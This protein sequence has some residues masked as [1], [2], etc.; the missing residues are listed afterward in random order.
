MEF[1]PI[2]I[3]YRNVALI[4]S[5]MVPD[6]KLESGSDFRSLSLI[7][8]VVSLLVTRHTIGVLL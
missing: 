7:A 2:V 1:F 6:S 8:Q 5:L 3:S 4:V